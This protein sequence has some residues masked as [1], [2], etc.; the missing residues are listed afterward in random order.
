MSSQTGVSSS[1][2]GELDA[3]FVNAGQGLGPILCPSLLS[4][5]PKEAGSLPNWGSFVDI[6]LTA[7]SLSSL[8]RDTLYPAVRTP[9]IRYLAASFCKTSTTTGSHG[10]DCA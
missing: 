2:A 10:I 4:G 6:A 9:E 5:L 7:L 3:G 1:S 8:A